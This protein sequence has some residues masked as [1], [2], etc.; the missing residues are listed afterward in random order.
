M[1]RTGSLTAPLTV[2]I[3]AG[4]SATKL[5]DYRT[6]Q[7]DLPSSFTIPAGV[8]SLRLTIVAATDASTEPVETATLTLLSD[9]SYVVGTPNAATFTINDTPPA[10]VSPPAGTSTQVVV[11]ALDY[12][13]LKMPNPGEY[14]L[15]ILS[16][17]M[18]ELSLINSKLPTP[19]TVTMWN[20]VDANNQFLTPALSEGAVTVNGAAVAVQSVGFK[21][22]PFYAPV[23]TRDLRL[24]NSLYVNLAA[25]IADGATV[26]V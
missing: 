8:S 9:P 25:P 21:R 18:L 14:T 10:P 12:L 4:G 24:N 22:R 5:D 7:N 17:T 19:G 6:L 26:E 11:S 1:A 13:N 2:N 15:H 23:L 3:S 20:L 16:P